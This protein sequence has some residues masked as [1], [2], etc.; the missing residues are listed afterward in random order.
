M[1]GIMNT[2]QMNDV[3]LTGAASLLRLQGLCAHG[4]SGFFPHDLI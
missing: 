2:V 4:R 3:H 1:I